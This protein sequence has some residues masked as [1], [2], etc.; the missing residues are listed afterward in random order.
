MRLL[1]WSVRA[2]RFARLGGAFLLADTRFQPAGTTATDRHCIW[3]TAGEFHD[4]AVTGASAADYLLDINDMAAVHPQETTTVEPRFDLADRKRAEK[5]DR[6]IEKKGV[7]G[8]R[9][10]GHH[11][12]HGQ[13]LGSIRQ[14]R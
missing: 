1:H 10:H 3:C 12:V 8:I 14:W 7:V 13:E 6:A 4:L 9:L 2:R 5:L 11:I